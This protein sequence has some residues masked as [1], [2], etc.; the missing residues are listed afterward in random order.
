[1]FTYPHG[2][3]LQEKLSISNPYPVIIDLMTGEKVA[4]MNGSEVN[5]I[6]Q[7]MSSL[8]GPLVQGKI[9]ISLNTCIHASRGSIKDRRMPLHNTIKE[10]EVE[11]LSIGQEFQCSACL[12]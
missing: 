9:F 4:T 3:L 2:T 1:V 7:S 6:V 10:R 5:R 8:L 12:W 11:N